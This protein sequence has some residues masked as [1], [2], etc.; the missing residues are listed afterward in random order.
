MRWGIS[1]LHR[2]EAY[3]RAW[4]TISI[5]AMTIS[6]AS[7]AVMVVVPEIRQEIPGAILVTF[8]ATAG[9]G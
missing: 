1:R 8:G 4:H 3:C 6:L 5:P 9:L 7:I 2:M